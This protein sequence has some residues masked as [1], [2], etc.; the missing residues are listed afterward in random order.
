MSQHDTQSVPVLGG[1]GG[2]PR[3]SDFPDRPKRRWLITVLVLVVAAGAAYAITGPLSS[4]SRGSKA[5]QSADQTGTY[6]ITRRNLSSQSEVS[7]TI[8]YAGSYSITAPSGTSSTQVAQ[9]E[10]ALG[11]DQ[12]TLSSD[13]Q[14][15]SAKAASDS[16]TVATAQSAVDAAQ[17]TLS[18]DQ[19]KQANDC[20][21]DSSASP[22]SACGTDSQK[23]SSDQSALSQAK[24]ALATANSTESTDTSQNNAK[25]ASDEAKVKADQEGLASLKETEANPGS[26]F[27]YL[28]RAG[29]VVK[30]DQAAY[31]LTNLPVPLLYG[32][33]PASRAFY[34]GMSDGPDV[35]EL[36]DD[37]ISLGYGG[38]L[39]SSSH[40]SSSTEAAV[41]AWQSALGLPVTGEILLGEVVFEPGP[42]R[43]TSVAASLGSS[44]SGGGG[45]GGGGGVLDATSTTRQV[46]IALDASQQS[47]VSVGD[48][49]VITLPNNETTK[50]V[51]SFV[52]TV[53]T[54]SSSA[55]SGSSGSSSSPT[56]TVL[57]RPTDPKATG[58]WDQ[59]PVNVT[60]TTAQ[61]KGALVVP[62]DAL[63]A[64]PSG[65]YALEV[66]G[67]NGVDRLVSVH[68]GLFD[69]ADGLVQVSG[70]GLSQGERVVV[71]KL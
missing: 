61:V 3:R 2:H 56:I 49:V 14:I 43:V 6:T 9:A 59:A 71:P 30:E 65:G 58:D 62:I 46:S 29:E 8:G 19:K 44:L 54:T 31:G 7:A 38:G 26:T 68:L 25:V 55:G 13:Q 53:A 42:I 24:A 64:Q 48:E 20:Q 22:G 27:T 18:A 10:Q 47:E 60:I 40:F 50:G 36:T 57:V 37:L 28:P 23:V 39:T 32:S 5:S 11:Q 34:L 17:S 70:A 51:I 45:G 33:T 52:G 1:S 4:K 69:D 63:R 66:V 15:A 21:G 41:K 16:Q 12:A 35:R 67:A